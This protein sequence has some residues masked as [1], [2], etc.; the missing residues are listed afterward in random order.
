MFRSFRQV[1]DED[2]DC[3]TEHPMFSMVEQPGIGSYLVPGVPLEFSAFEREAPRRASILG[4]HTD[5]I[6]AEIGLS[7]SE[8][9]TLH[10]DHIVAGPRL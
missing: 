2:K 10:A 8:I 1:V 5:K 3:S 4:E 7:D 6:L 9:S